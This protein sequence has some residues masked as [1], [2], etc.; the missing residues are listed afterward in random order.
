MC[1]TADWASRLLVVKEMGLQSLT[2]QP[3]NITTTI[4]WKISQM[5]ALQS[6]ALKPI[7]WNLCLKKD[8]IFWGGK[9][10]STVGTSSIYS[11]LDRE[12]VDYEG[13]E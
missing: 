3:Y 2:S 11:A 9:S 4:Y 1:E 12:K 6:G 10:I 5:T 8:D 7:T 13:T